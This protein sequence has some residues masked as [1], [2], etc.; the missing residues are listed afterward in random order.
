[1]A[2]L[3]ELLVEANVLTEQQLEHALRL[4]RQRGG[5]LGTHLVELGF[6]SEST[7]ARTLAKQLHL[8]ATSAAAIEK[9]P[10]EVLRLLTADLAAHYRAVPVRI[11]GTHLWMAMS[12]PT[13]RRCIAELD[14]ATR[15]T[16]R[17]MV[18]SDLL[19]AWALETHYGVRAR[20]RAPGDEVS[21]HLDLPIDIDESAAMPVPFPRRDDTG[22]REISQRVQDLDQRQP[23]VRLGLASLSAQ[24]V[25]TSTQRQVLDAALGFLVQ[26]FERAVALAISHGKL[27]GVT[28]Q[29][30]GVSD[31][32]VA[33]FAADASS[34]PVIARVL[35]DGRPRLGLAS[36]QTLGALTPVVG[37]PGQR[38]ALILPVRCGGEP[39]G[40]MVCLGG[41][42]G[43]ERYI[44]EYVATAAKLDYALQMLVL[45]RHIMS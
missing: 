2:R 29:G 6:V 21:P 40:C 43:V 41:H 18:C 16:V 45:K 35:G 44:D 25:T 32:T 11:E 1:M 4:Q 5:R 37:Q 39:V 34:I 7:L 20:M 33:G 28:A 30:F 13:D 15:H 8:P 42:D 19:I 9:V 31:K 3:G 14:A 38:A 22:A 17:P 26:D 12:D 27:V 24:L 23:A 10:P 36:A